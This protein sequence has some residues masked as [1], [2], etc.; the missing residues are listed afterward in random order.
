MKHDYIKK[1]M[2]NHLSK[3]IHDALTG[4]QP[5][6]LKLTRAAND[7]YTPDRVRNPVR[8][9]EGKTGGFLPKGP[10]GRSRS[11]G[12]GKELFPDHPPDEIFTPDRVQN[13]VGAEIEPKPTLK[14]RRLTELKINTEYQNMNKNQILNFLQT[15]NFTNMKKQILFLAFFVLAALASIT[16]SYGQTS[17]HGTLDPRSLS[18]CDDYPL[19]PLPGKAYT[20]EVTTT[21]T[22]GTVDTYTWWAT[23]NPD[24][25]NADGSLNMTG[26]LTTDTTTGDLIATSTNY[27]GAN[28]T[29]T[30]SITWSPAIL[31]KTQYQGT[32]GT[33][34]SP[35]FVAVMANG[36]CTNNFKVYEINPR[37]AFTVDV[38]GYDPVAD[39][40]VAFG[41]TVSSCVDEVRDALYA[42]GTIT[43]DYGTNTI[44]FEVVAANFVD[45]WKPLLAVSGLDT[46]QSAT[47]G[48]AYTYADAIAGNY[49]DF[50]AG[51]TLSATTVSVDTDEINTAG[52]VS[53]YVTVVVDNNTYETLADQVVTLT[54]DGVDST[55]QWDLMA[56]CT[57]N[58][59]ADQ[60]DEAIQT[61]L[62]RPTVTDATN[63]DGTVDPNDV[64]QPA[65]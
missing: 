44:T 33:D 57:D 5:M 48:W 7:R 18:G 11:P 43:M 39:A 47:I 16:D 52:G 41:N 62:A 42:G 9:A 14:I 61:I 1:Q 13:L 37:K 49:E 46:D 63:D 23:K 34:P 40:A 12:V 8:G 58:N 3:G 17:V 2:Q 51:A 36:S 6:V 59:A 21:T 26:M 31:A 15:L 4:T 65:P 64:I 53:I 27:G 45:T 50:A 56:D 24:F 28:A 54:V 32:V 29:S 38:S 25:V 20:Y 55:G 10:P 22:N 30:V 19:H 35:T 60:D